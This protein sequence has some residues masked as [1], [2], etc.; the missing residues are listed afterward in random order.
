MNTTTLIRILHVLFILFML[1]TPF[2]P[3]ISWFLV[4]LH[5]TTALSLLIHW[6]FNNDTCFLTL[7]EQKIRGVANTESFM[8][9]LVSPVYKISDECIRSIVWCITPILG[10]VSFSRLIDNKDLVLS[11]MREMKDG[12]I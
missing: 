2:V 8:H 7:V 6:Y 9:S 5:A 10:Y 4:L 3:N 1:I 11:Y 12:S